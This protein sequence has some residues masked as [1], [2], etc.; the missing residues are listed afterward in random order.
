[1][2]F[3]DGVAIKIVIYTGCL[4]EATIYYRYDMPMR[5]VEKWK[6]Y[7]EYLAALV[8]TRN[9]YRKV[10]LTISAQQNCLCG[11]DYVSERTKNLLRSKTIKLK[12]IRMSKI[13]DDLFGMAKADNEVQ[14]ELVRREIEALEN[15]EFN[16][17]V[18]PT[19]IN[20]IRDYL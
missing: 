1:M 16:Y 8:K 9:P 5:I 14:I 20:K 10:E 6:W 15:G 3:K 19:Y 7:F 4:A 13:E 17:Y 18:P 12:K 11:A 2:K